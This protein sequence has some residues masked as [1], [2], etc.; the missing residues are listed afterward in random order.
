VS[1]QVFLISNTSGLVVHLQLNTYTSSISIPIEQYIPFPS[2]HFNM[3]STTVVEEHDVICVGA[4]FGSI[5]TT[6]R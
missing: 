4:G 3:T 2:S 6:V 1:S 5:A